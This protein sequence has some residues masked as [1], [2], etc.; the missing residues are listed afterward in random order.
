[1]KAAEAQGKF[2]YV[3]NSVD[4]KGFDAEEKEKPIVAPHR[5]E[6]MFQS[7]PPPK[8]MAPLVPTPASVPLT[9]TPASAKAPPSQPQ[10]SLLSDEF[11]DPELDLELEGIN[12]DG[13]GEVTLLLANTII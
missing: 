12:L 3:P 8:P 2:Q 1:M 5:N 6:S 9:A 10:K 11:L 13:D 4:T 7:V